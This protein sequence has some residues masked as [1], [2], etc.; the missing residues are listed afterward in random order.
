MSPLANSP[1]TTR[2]HRRFIT[3]LVA[4]SAFMEMLDGT[5]IVTAMPQMGHAFNTSAVAMNIG[6]TAYLLALAVFMPVTGWAAERFG[7]RRLFAGAVLVFTLASLLC[8]VSS[9]LPMFTAARVLQGIGGAAMLPVGRL[10]VLRV[11]AKEELVQA[12]ATLVWPGLIA[13]VLGPLIGGF[14]VTYASWR[15]IFFLNLPL[16][17][18]A[19]TL[20]LLLFSD[21]KSQQQKPLDLSGFLLVGVSLA[22]LVF[23]LNALGQGG[24]D[25]FFLLAWLVAGLVL[26]GFAIRHCKRKKFPLLEFSALRIRTYA[27][28]LF[29]GA[30]FRV[31]ISSLPFLLPL[32]FQTIFGLNAF[33]SGALLL[34]LFAGNLLM[35][36]FTTRILRRFGFR[37]VLVLNGLLTAASLA[38]C[39]WFTPNTPQ[40]LIIPVLFIGGAF[41]SMQFTS[42]SS[43]QFADVP[44]EYMTGANTLSSMTSQLMMGLSAA[45]AAFAL[46]ASALWRGGV[47]GRPELHDFQIAFYLAGA[48]ACLGVLACLRLEAAAAQAVSGHQASGSPRG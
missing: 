15:W 16:G 7:V 10:A 43:L 19:F 41:R 28:S 14:L 22:I 29:G 12:I 1:T 32:L 23:A 26:G 30:L 27:I 13:P 35:K 40:W 33:I 18:A 34:S 9:G 38:A 21:T 2:S 42:L 47:A 6:V 39:A 20:A 5:V 25:S 8:G 31:S 48:I 4:G 37:Q 36:I 24:A 3:L 45:V 17:L 44:P 46:N 11:T